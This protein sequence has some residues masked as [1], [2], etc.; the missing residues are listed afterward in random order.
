MLFRSLSGEADAN[1]DRIVT[2]K[3]LF[4]FVHKGVIYRSQDK[5]HPVMWGKFKTTMPVIKW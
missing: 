1:R 5:Q 4:D 2:A 3:E